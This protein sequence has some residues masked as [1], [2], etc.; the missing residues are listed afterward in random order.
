MPYSNIGYDYTV[1]DVIDSNN[2]KS[3]EVH[4]GEGGFSQV[5]LGAGWQLFKGFSLGFNFSYFWG[6]W[7][8]GVTKT[9]NITGAKTL[10]RTYS[11]SVSSYKL[12]L[13]LQYQRPIDA[14]NLLTVGAT[15]SYGHSLRAQANLSTMS[16]DTSSD[17]MTSKDSVPDALSLPHTFGVGL[18]LVHKK[19]L[20]V[21]LDYSF[22]KWSSLSFPMF[23]EAA[24]RYQLRDDVF[25][26]RHKVAVGL[27]WI[28]NPQGRKSIL[29]H[30]H[31]RLGGSYAT[32]YYNMGS[33]K[34]PGEMTVSAGL[35][36]PL[37]RS[38]LNISGQWV[39]SSST[40]FVTENSF[41]LS[42][43]LT[44]NERWFAKWK[45]D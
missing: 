4:D 42:I 21:G 22:Q 15:Y 34:G 35:G 23:N 20:T 43:G 12:D 5:F 13:G 32:P 41:R 3:T 27:D 38:M 18:S 36:I 33:N 17:V 16:I 26:D 31:Y 45:V 29:Q 1:T 37:S 8:R 14:D 2:T 7:D 25:K 19:S 10:D 30:I 39:H 9:V 11:V 40:N 24:S 6:D 28:P 44:F